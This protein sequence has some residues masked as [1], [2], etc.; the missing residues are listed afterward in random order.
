MKVFIYVSTFLGLNFKLFYIP[1]SELASM[2]PPLTKNFWRCAALKAK[3]FVSPGFF[4]AHTIFQ[5][6]F[7]CFVVFCPTQNNTL[8]VGQMYVTRLLLL[9]LA[10]TANSCVA[11]P[12]GFLVHN[13]A[14]GNS[15]TC[16]LIGAN[17]PI[18]LHNYRTNFHS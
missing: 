7:R 6:L 14:Q 12:T 9:D 15:I 3:T 17:D 11:I 18:K 2:H 4:Y 10:I 1:V 8:N 13:H 16:N 5:T